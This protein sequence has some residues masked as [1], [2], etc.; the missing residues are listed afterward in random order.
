MSDPAAGE[1]SAFNAM[2]KVEVKET[3]PPD[4]EQ[5]DAPVDDA[6]DDEDGS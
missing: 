5:V 1:G 6:D 2:V 4:E 3:P